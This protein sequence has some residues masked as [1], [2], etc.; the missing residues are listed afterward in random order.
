M[1]LLWEANDLYYVG[2]YPESRALLL[3]VIE[4]ESLRESPY[5]NPESFYHSERR[6]A[7]FRLILISLQEQ[8]FSEAIFWKDWLENNYPETPIA[9]AAALLLNEMEATGTVSLACDKVSE[10]LLQFETPPPVTGS[11]LYESGY[12]NPSLGPEDI[13]LVFKTG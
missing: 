9:M 12:A 7:A 5:G 10:F 8:N 3:Q 13:C 11:L 6:F 4:D 1:H 2:D